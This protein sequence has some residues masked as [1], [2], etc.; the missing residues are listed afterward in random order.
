[1]ELNNK[2]NILAGH[3]LASVL[4]KDYNAKLASVDADEGFLID[5]YLDQQTISTNDFLKLEKL[6]NKVISGANPI[7]CNLFDAANANFENKYYEHAIQNSEVQLYDVKFAKYHSIDKHQL[8]F[9]STN[10]AKFVKL[11]SVGGSYWLG[12]A[13]NEQLI[14]IRGVACDN[15]E[16]FDSYIKYYND[17]LERDHRTIGKNLDLFTFNNLGGQGMPFWLPNGSVIRKEVR[18]FLSELEFKYG[19]DSVSTP[20]LGSVEL[21][22][23]SGH[24]DHYQENM[25]PI[26]NIEN[27]ELVLRPMTCPHH[28]LIYKNKP[29]S[30]KQLPLRLCEESILHRYESS[31]GLTGFERVREM[32]LEDVHIFCTPEQLEFEILNCYNIIK[33]AHKGLG[34]QI[35][36]IDLS[37]HDPMDKEKFHEDD[38]MWKMAEDS[39]R[40]MLVKHNI[41]FV[42]KVGEAAFYGPKIDFQVK[43]VLNRIITISTIQLDFL[44]PEKFDLTYKSSEGDQ[45][46]TIMV[47]LGIIGTYERLLSIMLEQ[48]KGALPLWLSPMQALIIPV[49]Y[50]IHGAYCE[51]LKSK[52][53]HNMIRCEI[54]NRD[55][56]MS[57]KIRDAQIGKIP[58]QIIIGDEELKNNNVA[59]RKYGFEDSNTLSIEEFTANL[60]KDI[61]EKN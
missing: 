40:N 58:Y 43:T 55:E 1:M 18:N 44:L 13:N 37:L 22:K 32:T 23:Q 19:F 53:R 24:W 39:L 52:L 51:E 27:E 4:E 6:M 38:G 46:R 49:N 45:K 8:D 5:I 28:I 35:F 12:N 15:K 56:R 36:Q 33:D 30:Y 20:V 29:K 50:D 61:K 7:E 25:F 26:I 47:H 34:N 41:P 54:D 21:Y 11:L 9:K 48:T 10:V 31:G 60:L 2:L 57:K 42:E 14:R 17:R 16:Q 3:I 59:F